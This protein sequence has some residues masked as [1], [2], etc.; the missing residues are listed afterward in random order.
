MIAPV[1]LISAAMPQA[2]AGTGDPG[3]GMPVLNA[4]T[5]SRAA[6]PRAVPSCAA[7]LM[8]PEAVPRA[9]TGTLVPSLV[10]ATEDRPIPA[11][12]AATHTG[13]AHVLLAAGM[14]AASQTAMIA[15]PALMSRCA[16]HRA[17]PGRPVR[18]RR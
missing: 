3:S 5:S 17:R 10:A 13:S 1:K 7:V 4:A 12:P 6:M 11:P 16:G 9:A 8:I 18:S 15:R 2:I 14:S